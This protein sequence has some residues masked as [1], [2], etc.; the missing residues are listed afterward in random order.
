M[1]AMAAYNSAFRRLAGEIGRSSQPNDFD[2]AGMI[3]PGWHL[4]FALT[5]QRLINFWHFIVALTR[6][7][8]PPVSLPVPDPPSEQS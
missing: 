8:E 6:G 4:R 5:S 2:R 3:L 1:K 7:A